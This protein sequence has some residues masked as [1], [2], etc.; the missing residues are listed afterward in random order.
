MY[1]VKLKFPG[2]DF[3]EGS[4]MTHALCF[5]SQNKAKN[6][7]KFFSVFASFKLQ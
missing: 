1:V 4:A 2:H 5:V 6:D 3:A 7:L